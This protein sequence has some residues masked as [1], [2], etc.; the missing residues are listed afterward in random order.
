[1]K[2]PHCGQQHANSTRVCPVQGLQIQS[3]ECPRC[4]EVL[5]A[6]SLFCTHCGLNLEEPP[7]VI[8]AAVEAQPE[9]ATEPISA[10]AVKTAQR[11]RLWIFL[12]CVGLVFL[13]GGG[14][15][16]SNGLSGK[17]GGEVPPVT[18]QPGLLTPTA[19]VNRTST[20]PAPTR[21]PIAATPPACSAVGQ[22]WVRPTDQMEMVCIP[23]GSFSIGQRSC[24]YAGCEKEVNGG[25]VNLEGYWI[26]RTEVTN[27]MFKQ[28]VTETN[29][30]TGAEKT[31]ASAVNGASEPV[32]A[33]DWRH[34]QGLI[35]SIDGLDNHPVVQMNWYAANAY[36]RW[37]GAKLPTEA[38]WEKAARG[39][40]GRLFPWGNTLPLAVYLNAADSNLPEAW[41]RTDQND[42]F[43]FT[44][45]VGTYPAGASPFGVLDMAGNAW[46]WTRSLYRDYPY[47][48]QDG[49]E[50][51]GDP[52]VTDKVVLRG[53]CWY[54]DYGSVRSTLRYGGK[55][56]QSTDGIGFRCAMP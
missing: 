24:G 29:F 21:T 44:A 47:L 23:A 17:K 55:A 15:L 36:C 8:P 13:I 18:A 30:I 14:I 53:G 38:Q 3:Y 7:E 20:A 42:G 22:V 43:R 10:P 1:M 26:D 11:K 48:L 27:A 16:I 39:T 50:L 4:G 35:S 46:E 25:N 41:A 12:L 49:R 2:C 5:W 28:F 45:P 19:S 33:A 32:P 6:G 54:D 40:D 37:I 51:M 52:T 56:D 34:P 9:L 31:G